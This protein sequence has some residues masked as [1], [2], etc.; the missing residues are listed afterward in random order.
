ML[1]EAD[2]RGLLKELD[3]K[4]AQDEVV[5]ELYLVGGAVMSL[6]YHARPATKDVDGYF[7]P[8]EKIRRAAEAI[9][10]E[11]ELP[12]NWLNDAVKGFLSPKGRFDLYLDLEHLK[13]FTPVPEYLLA[14]KCL[15]MRLGKEFHDEADILFLIRYLNIERYE[16]AI[17][18]IEQYYPLE[19]IP[20]KTLYALEEL[21]SA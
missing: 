6:A 8:K 12:L 16:D 14:L 17:A 18:I 11:R 15:A 1:S 13:V 3:G 10:R 19:R 7:V 4:L 21:L 20:Q 5:G 9:A 2:I